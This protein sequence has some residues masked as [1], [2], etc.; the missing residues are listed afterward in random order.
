MRSLAVQEPIKYTEIKA[1]N[2]LLE[3]LLFSSKKFEQI[4][5]AHGTIATQGTSWGLIPGPSTVNAC[6]FTVGIWKA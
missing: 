1:P 5:E 2:T 4:W 6:G 3:E